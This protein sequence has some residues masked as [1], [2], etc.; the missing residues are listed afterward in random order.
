M[1]SWKDPGTCPSLQTR[2]RVCWHFSYTSEFRSMVVAWIAKMHFFLLYIPVLGGYFSAIVNSSLLT[3]VHILSVNLCSCFWEAFQNHRS[4]KG[5]F[6]LMLCLQLHT[7][8][9]QAGE[10]FSDAKVLK[11][12]A[13]WWTHVTSY[14]LAASTGL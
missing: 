5:L 11:L 8:S 12:F 1:V 6:N 4:K 3:F 14:V 10:L 9:W 7:T 2:G 13:S